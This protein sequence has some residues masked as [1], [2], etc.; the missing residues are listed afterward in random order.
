MSGAVSKLCR[1]TSVNLTR[2]E[3]AHRAQLISDVHYAMSL[4]LRDA[5]DLNHTTFPVE[6][7]IT[8]TSAAGITFV[9]FRG[10]VHSATLDGIELPVDTYTETHGLP[11][12]VTT[13]R[14]TLRIVADATY[15]TTG[16]GLHRFRDPVDNEVYL[17]SQCETAD[18]KRIFPCFDQPDIK[19][20]YDMSVITPATWTVV[21][22][23]TI[24]ESGV[25]DEDERDLITQSATV[26]YPLSTY[27]IAFCVGPWHEVRDEWRGTITEHPETTAE[28]TAAAAHPLQVSGELSVPLGLYCRQSLAQYLDA[29]ELFEVTK[30]GFDWYAEHFGIAYPFYKYDQIFCPEYNMGAMENAGAVTI[31]D[32]YI[33]QSAA[34][35]YEYERRADTILH[36]LAHMWFGDLVTMRWWDDLWLNESFA[37][38]SASMSQSQATKFDTAWVT[39]ANKEKAWAYG[40]DQLPSTHPVFSDAQDI[41]T[42]EANF[43][44]ITYAKGASVLKQLAAYVGLDAF[45][46]GIRAHFAANAWSN[47]TFDDLLAALEKASGR[48]LSEWAAEWLKT[49]GI[50]TLAAEFEVA[51][52]GEAGEAGGAEGSPAVYSDFV[53]TQSGAAPGAGETRT[54]RVGVGVYDLTAAGQL[55]RTTFVEADITGERTR[56]NEL[57]GT[58]AG[59]FV[60][61]NDEDLAY[62]FIEIDDASLSTATQ[63]IT[64]LASPMARSLVWSAAWQMTRNASMRARDFVAL[65]ARGAAAETELAVLEQII[66]Q[67]RAALSRYADPA[68]AAETG[69]E[70]LQAA[71]LA[72]A[73]ETT[74]QSQLAFIRGWVACVHDTASVATVE[75]LLRG[76]ES[77]AGLTIDQEL[78]WAL[79]AALAGAARHSDKSEEEIL[80]LIEAETQ[81]DRS[82]NGAMHAVRARAA[83][84][85]ADNKARVW[86]WLTQDA[87]QRTNLELRH[88]GLGFL[89]PGQEDLLEPYGPAY[90]EIAVQLWQSL[91][92]EMGLRTLEQLFPSWDT[93]ADLTAAI[94]A[95][96]DDAAT[97]TG[98]RRILD[99]GLSDIERSRRAREFDCAEN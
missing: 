48:D 87:A 52:A 1:M 55:E 93:S 33:F 79:L 69:W 83:L 15:S 61:V 4:D 38:W 22:N 43:D 46:A 51:E 86:K 70:Q 17:Y 85:T 54:H 58:P 56:I 39:F 20:T 66:A 92:S 89:A 84:S 62:A 68:W 72:G 74:G 91:P 60:L 64:Q 36:E 57:I 76:D 47:A 32:E 9:D 77:I 35:H 40:Q 53:I 11:L 78:R 82:S 3:A 13:G 19:A 14:H 12:P 41:E 59:A 81:A 5:A 30:Q 96:R 25:A 10:A 88:G 6:T 95:V 94:T 75:A 28:T 21:T 23:N 7:T 65:V 18:A 90:A 44:G 98:L 49:T 2:V 71:L 42:V 80:D 63:H 67:S 34:S 27:L 8:F 73:R 97:P 50:N 45:L 24:T 26:D 31:R 16:Q 99:E 29:E 37:T